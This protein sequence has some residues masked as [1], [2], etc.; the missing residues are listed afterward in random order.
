MEMS[1]RWFSI[2][3]WNVPNK[4]TKN[5]KKKVKGK[6]SRGSADPFAYSTH[7]KKSQEEEYLIKREER[8]K[9]NRSSHHQHHENMVITHIVSSYRAASEQFYD[10]AQVFSLLLLIAK[11]KRTYSTFFH[12]FIVAHFFWLS[13]RPSSP[14][15]GRTS[16]F[17]FSAS[18]HSSSRH[19][20]QRK[21]GAPNARDCRILISWH[22][23]TSKEN[24][25]RKWPQKKKKIV[26]IWVPP[27]HTPPTYYV[28]YRAGQRIKCNYTQQ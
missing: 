8:K 20:Q 27:T 5:K 17:R 14:W 13:P 24:K 12:F 3:R 7:P 1:G 23:T 10:T 16:F 9:N 4:K 26:K 15:T 19:L 11:K 18:S 21:K 22:C 6:W 25:K 28:L 2:S